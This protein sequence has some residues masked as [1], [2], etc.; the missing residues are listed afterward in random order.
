MGPKSRAPRPAKPKDAAPKPAKDAAPKPAPKRVRPPASGAKKKAKTP[1]GAVGA[2][3]AVVDEAA[4]APEEEEEAGMG[5]DPSTDQ[6]VIV[7][8]PGSTRLRIGLANSRAPMVLPN[9]V[10]WRRRPA[11]S[12]EPGPAGGVVDDFAALDEAVRP[13]ARALRIGVALLG[14]ASAADSP[15]EV[16]CSAAAVAVAAAEEA[17]RRSETPGWEAPCGASSAGAA[18]AHLDGSAACLVGE[19][20]EAAARADP[21]AWLLFY[22]FQKGALCRRASPSLLRAALCAIW[23]A[24]LFGGC[25]VHGLG[26]AAAQLADTCAVLAL[27]D[28]FAR[29]DANRI[30]ELLL[31]IYLDIGFTGYMYIC[32]MFIC[33]YV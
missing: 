5:D 7:I 6:P 18:A 9:C 27:P 32:F 15:V 20:A 2:P 8:H 30:L 14:D 16:E 21:T 17:D 33:V 26:L 25:G 1:V 10:A 11:S 22:P 3:A 12:G 23:R 19:A 13:L 24:A 29:G 4:P 31:G 28:G